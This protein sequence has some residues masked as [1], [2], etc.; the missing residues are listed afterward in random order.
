MGD[1]YGNIAITVEKKNKKTECF[2]TSVKCRK[3][4]LNLDI[5]RSF[6]IASS[7][8]GGEVPTKKVPKHCILMMILSKYKTL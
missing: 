3:P 8:L 4:F 1:V 7:C 2:P 5:I 6:Y